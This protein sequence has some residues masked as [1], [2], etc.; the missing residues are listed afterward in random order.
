MSRSWHSVN[1]KGLP[2]GK[3]MSS[4][5]NSSEDISQVKILWDG[6]M[7]FNV[8]R[9]HYS[10]RN[11]N[12]KLTIY[13]SRKRVPG[14]DSKVKV[15]VNIMSYKSS[16][17]NQETEL[18][19]SIRN[20]LSGTVDCLHCLMTLLSTT[21]AHHFITCNGTAAFNGV[22]CYK[23]EQIHLKIHSI[24]DKSRSLVIRCHILISATPRLG[25]LTLHHT[26]PRFV[27]LEPKQA[28]DFITVWISKLKIL[29]FVCKQDGIT[30]GQTDRQ[31]D[32][33]MD[34]QKIRLLHAHG[35]PFGSKN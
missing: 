12:T 31:M 22:E 27:T 28:I 32:G 9:F 33:R 2:Q 16:V 29:H 21:N 3:N 18:E 20:R 13:R 17:W 8:P 14:Q 30:D 23:F 10:A 15:Q 35:G 6:W 25:Y 7:S 19:I 4:I 24:S 1:C 26:G 11:K 34:R 5:I